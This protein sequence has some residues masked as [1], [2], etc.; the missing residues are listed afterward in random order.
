[1]AYSEGQLSGSAD[2]RCG[3]NVYLVSQSA[4]GNNSTFYWEVRLVYPGSTG[5][6]WSDPVA[7]WSAYL[8]GGIANPGGNFARPYSDRNA[9]VQYVGSGY[10]TAPHDSGGY[11]AGMV[12]NAYIGTSHASVGSGGSGDAWVDAPRIPKAPGV[13]PSVT[14]SLLDSQ[15]ARISWGASEP[16]GDPVRYYEVQ[17]GKGTNGVDVLNEVYFGS[18]AGSVLN[19][20]WRRGEPGTTYYYRV[21]ALNGASYP[22][23]AFSSVQSFTTL[24]GLYVSD[25]VN[26]VG[27]PIR[28]SDGSS[29]ST[30]QPKVSDGDS[31]ENPI[32]Q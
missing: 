4:S 22:W 9:A 24:G 10:Y 32:S 30:P 20:D 15:G 31:W 1:M 18:V 5:A 13:P 14:A 12:N 17:I 21:R 11:R 28:V 23:G 8:G 25:G 6:W 3:I 29:W 19:V 7:S 26:W 2:Y 16:N 27:V